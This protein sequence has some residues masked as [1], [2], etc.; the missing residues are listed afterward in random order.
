MQNDAILAGR[1]QLRRVIGVGGMGTVWSATELSS[2]RAIA[3]KVLDRTAPTPLRRRRFLGE[4]RA[5]MV[6]DHPHVVRIHEVVD[7]SEVTGEPPFLVMDLLEG[8]SLATCLERSPKLPLAELAPIFVQLVSAAGAAHGSGIIHRDLKPANVFLVGTPADVRVLDFGIAKLS[9]ELHG[10]ST[11][12]TST[13]DVLGTPHYMS[14]EQIFGESDIDQRSDVWSLGVIAFQC[15]AGAHPASVENV[16]QLLKAITTGKLARLTRV[17]PELPT[18]VS[19]LVD[20]MLSR[21]PDDRPRDL[22][23]VLEIFARHTTKRVPP[24]PPPAERV[25]G[26]SSPG[27]LRALSVETVDEPIDAHAPLERAPKSTRATMQPALARSRP[28]LVPASIAAIVA[29]AS[30]I[31]AV[32]R[33]TPTSETPSDGATPPQPLGSTSAP[34]SALSS[35]PASQV[36]TPAPP[37]VSAKSLPSAAGGLQTPTVTSS[38]TSS[39]I[40]KSTYAPAPP[41][42]VASAEEAAKEATIAPL[43]QQSESPPPA[44]SVPVVPVVPVV[45]PGGLVTKAP[46]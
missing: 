31:V 26:H 13:G 43:P 3:V 21:E 27:E 35:A 12:L 22:R 40:A 5:A 16:G 14:P 34:P 8:E 10:G 25:A 1:Y 11:G 9:A 30:G 6:L 37:A 23:E 36:A 33:R 18:D 29:L 38:A 4:A 17:A 42:V 45:Q 20:R 39:A 2:G 28:W 15:L 44:T 32:S 46:F 19:A 24:I 41:K 7:A